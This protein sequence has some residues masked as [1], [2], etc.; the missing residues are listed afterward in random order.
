MS[1]DGENRAVSGTLADTDNIAD[2]IDM[3][4]GQTVQ[5]HALCNGSSS[6]L[7]MESRSFDF[8]EFNLF[9]HSDF[10]LVFDEGHSRFNFGFFRDF[11]NE[12][13]NFGI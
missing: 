10:C 11:G 4:I 2:F 13:E 8:A 7:F 1:A 3:N 12:I 5:L 6:F 9:L